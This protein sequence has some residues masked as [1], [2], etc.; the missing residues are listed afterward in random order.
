MN[1]TPRVPPRLVAV[2][3]AAFF[4]AFGWCST[5]GGA[6]G[7]TTRHS[8]RALVAEIPSSESTSIVENSVMDSDERS[9][10][11]S[12]LS[13][14]GVVTREDMP[15]V[16]PMIPTGCHPPMEFLNS[17]PRFRIFRTAIE[18]TGLVRVYRM[19]VKT[20]CVVLRCMQRRWGRQSRLA[21]SHP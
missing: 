4:L 5:S 10:S 21:Y 19:L 16:A 15:P 9:P 17:D 8:G 18:E 12:G 2:V 7:D 6:V 20:T 13:T 3:V 11:P 1:S 14:L